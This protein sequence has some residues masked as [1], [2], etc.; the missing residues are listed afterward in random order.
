MITINLDKAKTIAHEKRR[1]FWWR[2]SVLW[3]GFSIFMVGVAVGRM[4]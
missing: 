1:L 4:I 3:L 2:M